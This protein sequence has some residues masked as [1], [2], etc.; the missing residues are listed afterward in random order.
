MT[1]ETLVDGTD[2]TE[3]TGVEGGHMSRNFKVVRYRLNAGMA[4]DTAHEAPYRY[5]NHMP[6]AMAAI[7]MFTRPRPAMRT[8]RFLRVSKTAG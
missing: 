3:W 2:L 1:L 7:R 8:I 5:H 6:C 4:S